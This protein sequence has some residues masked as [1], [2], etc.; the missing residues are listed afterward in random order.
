[1]ASLFDVQGR[2][3]IITGGGTGL[4]IWVA[5]ALVRGGAKVYITCRR[6]QIL[7]DAVTKLNGISQGRASYFVA[8]VTNKDNIEGLVNFVEKTESSVDLLVNNAAIYRPEIPS[9]F[10]DPLKE[11]Q[12]SLKN[13]KVE[14][15]TDQFAANTWAPYMVTVSFLHMLAKAAE[16]GAGRGSVVMVSS[17]A[18]RFHNPYWSHASYSS[19]KLGLEQITRILATKL[20]LHKVRVNTIAPGYFPT[21]ANPPEFEGAPAHE[22]NRERIPFRRNGGADDIAGPVIF[23]ASAASAYVTGQILDVDGGVNLVSNGLSR[24]AA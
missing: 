2:V 23:L 15:W 14:D 21:P 6:E 17:I 3:A 5:E 4:G 12:E 19:T 7:K 22:S 1:M 18:A 9:T 20:H 11:L 16:K 13:T 8:D 10:Q 24:I